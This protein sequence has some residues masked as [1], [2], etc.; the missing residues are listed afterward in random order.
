MITLE[1]I[2]RLSKLS[3]AEFLKYIEEG[4]KKMLAEGYK[5][6]N[7]PSIII[8]MSIEEFCKKTGAKTFEQ[9]KEDISKRFR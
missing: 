3:D 9:F 2:D 1:E 6:S 4:H 7:E 8:D 5:P